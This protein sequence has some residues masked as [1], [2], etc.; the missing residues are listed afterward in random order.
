MKR[1]PFKWSTLLIVGLLAANIIFIGVN[2]PVI[3]QGIDG[4][5]GN[6]QPETLSDDDYATIQQV[7][8]SI[9]ALYIEDLD[10][11]AL[12]KILVEKKQRTLLLFF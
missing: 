11:E 2:R 9:Q 6:E 10:K 5:F 7:Y 1:R 3:A 12:I 8:D 4:L